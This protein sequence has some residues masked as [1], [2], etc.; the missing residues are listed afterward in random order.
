MNNPL[1]NTS[2]RAQADLEVHRYSQEK[3]KWDIQI[4]CS[5]C[6]EWIVRY[7]A[8]SLELKLVSVRNSANWQGSHFLLQKE[9]EIAMPRFIDSLNFILE[10][11][12]E[13][14]RNYQ[15]PCGCS[16][17]G[18]RFLTLEQLRTTWSLG[19]GTHLATPMQVG[20]S[21]MEKSTN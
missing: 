9:L 15:I 17:S 10:D 20:Y 8:K 13:F 2:M 4:R 19:R 7:W 14:E 6:H 5:K 3:R 1:L 11:F 12:S 18:G 21:I 16:C